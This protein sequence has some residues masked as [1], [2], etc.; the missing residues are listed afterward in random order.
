MDALVT[1]QWLADELGA[2]DLRIV[3]AT[4]VDGASG[5]DPAA[6]YR[7][8][9]IPGAVFLNL[10]QLRDTSA[11]LPNTLP[12]AKTI[13][14]R[15]GILGIA[16]GDRIVLYDD[17]PWHTSARAWFLLRM[18][19][20]RNVAILDGG[21]A[22]WRAEGRETVAGDTAPRA[23]AFDVQPDL[24]KVRGLAQMQANLDTSPEQI[25]DARSAA[26]F[27]GEEADP[28]AGVAPGHIPGSSN[29]PYGKMFDADGLWTRGDA[30]KAAF[31]DA[32]IDLTKPIVTTCGSG[33]TAAVVAFGAHLLGTEAALYDG[34]WSEWGAN[35]ATPKET[36][37]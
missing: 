37:K 35:P 6:E 30:L 15:L 7:A 17:A 31:A 2:A 36:G 12:D 20:A 34:S 26:R 14:D 25:V 33:I 3:D 18:F 4:Y 19:G 22:R 10:A 32:G 5:R 28:R 16:S 11:D 1:T 29:L 8:G 27:T 21:I 13:A 24:R 23:A 9:H